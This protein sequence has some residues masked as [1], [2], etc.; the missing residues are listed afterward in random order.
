LTL[1]LSRRPYTALASLFGAFGALCYG[2]SPTAF[3][4][5]AGALGHGSALGAV[6]VF[7]G[8]LLVAAR[9]LRVR[10]GGGSGE[11]LARRGLSIWCAFYLTCAVIVIGRGHPF[12]LIYLLP[13][14]PFAAVL[15]GDVLGRG[16]MSLASG[17]VRKKRAAVLGAAMLTAPAAIGAVLY[18]HPPLGPHSWRVDDMRALADRV[19]ADGGSF[20]DVAV[21]IRAFDNWRIVAGLGVFEPSDAE[22]IA[23]GPE[24]SILLWTRP[25]SGDSPADAW[26]RVPITEDRLAL[27]RRYH[28]WLDM[29]S[30]TVCYTPSG[31]GAGE[32]CVTT[33]LHGGQAR[34]EQGFRYRSRAFPT[35]SGPRP[36]IPAGPYE[37][38]YR[39]HLRP[40]DSVETRLFQVQYDVETPCPWRIVGS[41]E[42]AGP[43]PEGTTVDVARQFGSPDCPDTDDFFPPGLFEVV[44][45]ADR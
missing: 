24:L 10:L 31:E 35:L 20:P 36:E 39:L 4:A 19:Y 9:W 15:L 38:T 26:S 23:N 33:G 2:L 17:V 11:P 18:P 29:G 6:V 43:I 5:N 3:L 40:T 45:L 21:R 28:S 1:T 12:E 25:D 44:G 32:A 42:V 34:T 13:V 14:S 22:P 41:P 27:V 8:L 16:A 37:A 30:V 7:G